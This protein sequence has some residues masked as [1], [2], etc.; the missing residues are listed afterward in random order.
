MAELS[1]QH[2]VDADA[3]FGD[4]SM[5]RILDCAMD[6]SRRDDVCVGDMISA[7]GP[8]SFLPLLLMPA[9]LLVSPLSGIPL[10]SSLCA[11]IIILVAIQM[12]AGRS[13]VWLP[14]WVKRRGLTGNQLRYGLTKVR[15]VAEWFDR[16]AHRRLGIMFRRPFWYFLPLSC[17]GLAAMIPFL[18]LVP[19][20][21]SLLGL[22]VVLVS[23]GMLTRDG[24]W[25]LAGVVPFLGALTIVSKVLT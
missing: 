23:L 14:S 8:A 4:W 15:P 10:F 20:S 1:S 9:L 2:E 13:C 11:L 16:N 19:F 7:F 24:L 25:V 22:S 18:E 21:S 6:V 12:I 5:T 3:S 17:V